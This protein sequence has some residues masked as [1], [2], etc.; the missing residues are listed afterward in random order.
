M[1]KYSPLETVVR[2]VLLIVVVISLSLLSNRIWGGKHEQ[3]QEVKKPIIEQ[4]MT[5]AEFGR[6]NALPNPVLKELFEL[7]SKADLEKKVSEY[8][9]PEQ[10]S[11]MVIKKLALASEHGNKNWVKIPVKFGLWFAFLAATF[12]LLKKRKMVP[13]LRNSLLLV[14]LFLFGIVLGSDPNPMGTVKDAIQLYGTTH[15]IFPPRL[16][17]LAV[18][19]FLV[20]LVNK[21]ICAW[22]CQAGTLQDLIFH[23]NRTDEQKAILG[24]QM[25]LPFVLTNS[26]RVLFFGMFT[27]VVF[28]WGVDIVE[29]I[30][31]FK[32]YKPMY[33]G[34]SGGISLGVLLL[35]SLFIYRP[36]CH[37]FCPFG[38]VGWLVEQTSLVRIS[39]NYETCIACRKCVVACPSTVMDAV[40]R[41]D[42]KTIPDCFGCYTCRDVCPT[43]SISFSIRKRTL[44]PPDF[45]VKGSKDKSL[46]E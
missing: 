17:A 30:D 21:F 8:G 6:A 22:G 39:V 7:K 11:A 44:P 28:A 35:A 42:K 1:A 4:E 20:F 12:I 10:I 9:T 38:L 34:L 33:L 45:F 5:V 16:I 19:L 2:F 37:L 13:G 3:V 27:L 32:V 40:L 25:K 46:K 18:F 23:I 24:R 15:A 41:R 31:P 36:W 26:V 29:P 43:D 14:S